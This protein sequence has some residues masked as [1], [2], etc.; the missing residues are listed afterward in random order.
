MLALVLQ[1]RLDS[2]RLP[3]KSLLP[4]GGKPLILR[5]ME[6][7]CHI[8]SDARVL[9]CPEDCV[10]SFA[11][12]AAETG[13]EL[14]AGPKEDVLERYC[15]AIRRYHIHQVIRATG[16]NPFV[17]TD[18]A[19]AITAEALALGADYAGYSGL[20]LGAG[21]ESVSA[22]ALLRAETEAAAPCE[23]EHVCPYLYGHPELFRLHR[24]LAPL[25]WCAPDMRLTV[26][27]AADYEKAQELYAALNRLA[28]S[29][30]PYQGP[31]II[32][33]YKEIFSDTASAAQNSPG[34]Q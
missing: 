25:R 24:P 29:Q 8:P 19:A 28:N 7:L 30:S 18:A 17:F 3:G 12:L 15:I 10:Q 20:P 13:F 33:L 34:T 22:A 11:P 26:D 32:K 14:L 2:S 6:A 21:V 31:A 4:L 23:R 5:V 9:A 1:A 16:D 27:T